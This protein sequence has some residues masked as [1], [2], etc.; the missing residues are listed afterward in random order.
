MVTNISEEKIKNIVS[1]SLNEMVLRKK[2]ETIVSESLNEMIKNKINEAPLPSKRDSLNKNHKKDKYSNKY[3]AV[4]NAL[5]NSAI[6]DAQ[7]AY[8]LWNKDEYGGP[9]G[10]RSLFSKMRSGKPEKDG[11][12]RKFSEE[13]INKLYEII[14]SI[15]N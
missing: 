12:I 14:R 1:E 7:L 3:K 11:T 13:E 6:T 5:K 9:D 4:M 2:I 10:Q 8:K 15:G